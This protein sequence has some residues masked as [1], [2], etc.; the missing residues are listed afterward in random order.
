MASIIANVDPSFATT[1]AR[2]SAPN[3]TMTG[4]ERRRFAQRRQSQLGLVL[5]R[6]SRPSRSPPAVSP[7][8]S[9]IYNPHYAPFNYYMSTSNPH[10]LP[11][12][13][14]A[15]IGTSADQANHNYAY[16]DFLNALA[17]GNLP[18]VTFLKAS[19]TDTG[20]PMDSTPL[21]EQNFLVDHHQCDRA[22]PVL[23]GHGDHHHL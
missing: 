16:S 11:P 3:V 15:A 19:E 7:P 13:S 18:S 5:R 9:R 14:I 10:H 12:T 4:K 1:I 6:I 17:A 22:E 20:H 8:A 23:E 2:G 21:A